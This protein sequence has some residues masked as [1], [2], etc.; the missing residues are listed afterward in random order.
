VS[1]EGLDGRCSGAPSVA[2][3]ANENESEQVDSTQGWMIDSVGGLMGDLLGMDATG[4][5]PRP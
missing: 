5:R 4:R 1:V 2:I 3:A